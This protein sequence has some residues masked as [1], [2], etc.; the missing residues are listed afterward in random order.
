MHPTLPLV[1]RSR[2][3][4]S[5]TRSLIAG[6]LVVAVVA[7]AAPPPPAPMAATPP[8]VSAIPSAPISGGKPF[9]APFQRKIETLPPATSLVWKTEA[10]PITAIVT[11]AGSH[12]GVLLLSGADGGFNGPESGLYE[13]LVRRLHDADV[14]ALRV[15]YRQPTKL[16]PSVEDARV[17]IDYLLDEGIDQIAVVGFSF[18]GAVAIEIAAQM[19]VVR[20]VLTLSAQNAETENVERLAPRPLAVVHATDDQVIPVW[21]AQDIYGR[22][23]EPKILVLLPAADHYLTDADPSLADLVFDWLLEHLNTADDRL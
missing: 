23:G 16:A 21:A 20:A 18:G 7:C 3:L 11:P 19:P 2:G 6:L 10:G 22:A 1:A 5:A 15:A 9:A 17:G 13:E 8:A 4:W 12:R 14:T